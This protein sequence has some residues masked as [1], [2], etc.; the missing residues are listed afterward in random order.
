MVETPRWLIR[1]QNWF[2][3]EGDTFTADQ[4]GVARFVGYV[5]VGLP[6]AMLATLAL[7]NCGYDSISHY[8][9]S[10]VGGEIF[11][12]ALSFI[13]IMMYFYKG[14]SK[15]EK[16]ITHPAALFALLVA[17]FPTSGG[18]CE[19]DSFYGR[20]FTTIVHVTKAPPDSSDGESFR[21]EAPFRAAPDDGVGP[22]GDTLF[23][24][25]PYTETIHYGAAAVLFAL[26]AIYALLIFPHVDNEAHGPRGRLTP[27]KRRRNGIYYLSFLVIVASMFMLLVRPLPAEVWD[28]WNFTFIFEATGLFAFGASWMA[29]GRAFAMLRDAKDAPAA[30]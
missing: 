27:A 24:P 1:W 11:V 23:S 14:K 13:A 29:R 22:V 20:G 3:P 25:A 4:Q 5:A 15:R 18:G 6:F 19:E 26:L 16:L 30:P 28:A 21:L 2:A 17:M 10:Y 9:Y 12:G 8:Y 7:G